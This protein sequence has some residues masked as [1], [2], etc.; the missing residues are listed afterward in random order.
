MKQARTSTSSMEIV[1]PPS[2]A[3]SPSLSR[4]P[5][6]VRPSPC[7]SF[8]GAFIASMRVH[9]FRG[10]SLDIPPGGIMEVQHERCAGLDVHKDSIVVCVRL[11]R[12][13]RADRQIRTFGT[14]TKDL[15]D[16]LQWLRD[17]SVTHVAM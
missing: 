1:T 2:G 12:G 14:C 17:V 8:F 6:F 11:A 5:G 9:F 15:L 13:S 7:E 10:L 3:S 4:I 16:L